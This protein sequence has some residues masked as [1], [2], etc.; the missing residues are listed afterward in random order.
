MRQF[1]SKCFGAACMMGFGLALVACGDAATAVDGPGGEGAEAPTWH[2]DIAPLVAEKC[3]QCHEAGGIAPFSLTD[4]EAA[5]DWAPLI[6]DAVESGRMPPFLAQETDECTPRLPWKD[7]LRLD[8]AQKAMLRAWADADAPEGDA[9]TAAE[10]VDPTPV[11]LEREDIVLPLPEPVE[12]SGTKD[13]HRCMVVDPELDADTYVVSS[14]VTSGNTAVLHHVVSYIIQPGETEQGEPRTKAQ[15]EAL[16]MQEKGVGIGG[17]YDCFGGPS[18]D[19]ISTQL[20]N[21]W[22]PGSV[23][24][25]APEEAGQPLSKE[26]LVLLDLHYHPT[27]IGTEMDADT[28]LALT[29]TDVEPRYIARNLFLGNQEEDGDFNLVQVTV[30]EDEDGGA[31]FLIPAGA[32]DHAEAMEWTFTDALT[33]PLRVYGIGTHMHYVGT[34]MLITLRN[35]GSGSDND[36]GEECLVQTPAWDFNWQRSYGFDATYD[37][38]PTINP[39]DTVYMRCLYDNSMANPFV[40]EA[41]DDQGLDAPVDVR[42]GDDTLDEMCLG[43]LGIMYP[44]RDYTP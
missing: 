20:L 8:D 27:G 12:V 30:M 6:A 44:N 10:V 37:E 17:A 4:Y 32:S 21:A 28:Y 3:T 19:G 24:S 39:G 43:V 34:D 23:P 13:M 25:R 1:E 16:L 18:L 11:L 5:S 31:E 33:Y 40:V 15:L 22:A 2:Q 29:T 26:S 7:D 14:L 41:L 36:H 38:L 42:L 35:D 9:A